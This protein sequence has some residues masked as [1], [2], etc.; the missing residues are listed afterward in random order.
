MSASG[1]L[2]L[3]FMV[4]GF[5]LQVVLIIHF[6]LRK[7]LFDVYI[8]KY[9]WVVYA[10]SIPAAGVSVALLLAG[11]TWWLWLGGFLYLVWAIYGYL[12]EYAARIE[13]RSPIRWSLFGPYVFLYLATIMFYWWPLALIRK[14]LWYAYAVLF[15]ISTILNVTSHRRSTS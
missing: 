10:L 13:W 5:A 3:L 14:P 6:C 7:W 4:C 12:V 15:V 2:Q 8:M 9:G 1:N 11:A